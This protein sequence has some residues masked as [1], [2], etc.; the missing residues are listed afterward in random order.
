MEENGWCFPIRPGRQ[1]SL[2]LRIALLCPNPW[3]NCSPSL[4]F[5]SSRRWSSWLHT[6]S[7]TPCVLLWCHLIWWV[8]APLNN[9]SLPPTS[10]KESF[11]QPQMVSVTP[12]K[13]FFC[14]FVFSQKLPEDLRFRLGSCWNSKKGAL[15]LWVVLLC[16]SGAVLSGQWFQHL[17]E[18]V[19]LLPPGGWEGQATFKLAFRKGGAIEF[20][21]MMMKAASAGEHC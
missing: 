9:Q 16:L 13:W 14:L 19:S 7:V 3:T 17:S 21:Q 1:S 15:L 11:R 6:Q 10:L 18:R 12:Q 5:L 20:A 8:T 2:D 4:K